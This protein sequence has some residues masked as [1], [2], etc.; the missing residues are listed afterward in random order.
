MSNIYCQG[1]KAAKITFSLTGGREGRLMSYAPPVYINANAVGF[2]ANIGFSENRLFNNHVI[3]DGNPGNLDFYWDFIEGIAFSDFV[4]L[5]AIHSYIQTE[6]GKYP[7]VG[8]FSQRFFDESFF[9]YYVFGEFTKVWSNNYKFGDTVYDYVAKVSRIKKVF[10]I[11]DTEGTLYAYEYPE[12][13]TPT[14]QV[15]CIG[16][17]PGECAGSDGKGGVVCMDC[18]QMNN[19]LQIIKKSLSR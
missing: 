6:K 1:A 5:P 3:F 8:L 9:V 11:K 19:D 17:N 14:W 4:E 12:G 10:L 2:R 15:E 16:C 18:K 7:S 13:F